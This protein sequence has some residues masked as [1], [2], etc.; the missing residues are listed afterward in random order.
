M[1]RIKKLSIAQ[2]G[3]SSQLTM[4]MQG[5][6]K[7]PSDAK[8]VITGMATNSLNYLQAPD[9]ASA[10]KTVDAANAKVAATQQVHR[11]GHQRPERS[12]PEGGHQ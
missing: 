11:Q 1:K 5:K 7:N 12:L 6:Q 4:G 8:A 9:L 2:V 10:Q 3:V